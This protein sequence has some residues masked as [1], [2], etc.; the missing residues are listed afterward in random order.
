MPDYAALVAARSTQG[1]EEAVLA[2]TFETGNADQL[3]SGDREVDLVAACAK[4]QPFR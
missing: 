2:V 1:V 4:P 3:A